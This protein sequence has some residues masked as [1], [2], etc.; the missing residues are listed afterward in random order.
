MT[1][2]M[3]APTQ[4]EL[5]FRGWEEEPFMEARSFTSGQLSVYAPVGPVSQWALLPWKISSQFGRDGKDSA[6]MT[7]HIK[8]SAITEALNHFATLEFN[9]SLLYDGPVE[10]TK[11]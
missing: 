4:P 3:E 7:Y 5:T 8:A 9:R 10:V 11:I 2:T 6:G 1:M